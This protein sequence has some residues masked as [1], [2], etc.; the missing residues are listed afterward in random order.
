MFSKKFRS[1]LFRYG[2][3]H[4]QIETE[5]RRPKPDTVRL[6]RLKRLRLAIKDGLRTLS[7]SM[8]RHHAARLAPANAAQ[9]SLQ[10]PTVGR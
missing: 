2:E 7:D 5:Q 6:L 4:E 8:A 1:L 3:I 9:Q 10:Q